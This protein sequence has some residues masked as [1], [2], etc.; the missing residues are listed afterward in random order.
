[1]ARTA[2]RSIAL[3]GLTLMMALV[4]AAPAAASP[5]TALAPNAPGFPRGGFAVVGVDA[6][7]TGGDTSAD[8]DPAVTAAL[9]ESPTATTEQTGVGNQSATSDGTGPYKVLSVGLVTLAL[10]MGILT[11]FYWKAT[12][13]P[14]RRGYLPPPGEG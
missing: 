1:M 4:A 8:V 10:L 7:P 3:I 14:A 5:S 6:A 12:V 9:Q 2:S 13:P 11:W